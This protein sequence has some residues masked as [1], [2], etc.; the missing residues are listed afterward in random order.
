MS[1]IGSNK[2]RAHKEQPVTV[3][4]GRQAFER[5]VTRALAVRREAAAGSAVVVV[6]IRD[7]AATSKQRGATATRRLLSLVGRVLRAKLD[8]KAVAYLGNGKFALLLEDVA[9]TTLEAKLLM[10]AWLTVYAVNGLPVPWGEERFIEAY[11]G[12]A[13]AGPHRYGH[14]LLNLAESAS[15]TAEG[16]FGWKVLVLPAR[17]QEPSELDERVV[18]TA[19]LHA[20]VTEPRRRMAVGLNPG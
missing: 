10:K 13:L 3:Y 11:A 2:I 17:T 8:P 18:T 12:A 19:Q 16:M 14:M 9:G 6:G 20:V 7:Y 5:G 15:R 1:R 4:L